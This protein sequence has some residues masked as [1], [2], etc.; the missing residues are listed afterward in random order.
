MRVTPALEPL[1]GIRVLDFTAFPPGGSCTVMLAD[2]GA[3]IIR[4]ESPAQKG[5][6]SLVVGQVALSRGKRSMTLDLRNPASAEV[7]RRLAATVDVIV[8]NAKPGS[9]EERGF[10]YAHAR[11]A[12]PRIIWCA[13]TGFGQSGPY[14]GHAGHDLSYLA[15][16]G[17]LGALTPE[18][19][20]QPSLSLSLQAG[21]FTAVVGIQAAL[22]QRV[23]SGEGAFIDVSLSEA[24]TW[25]LTCGI[26]PLSDHPFVLGATPDRRLYACADGRFVAV[27]CAEPRTWGVLCDILGVP[28]LENNLHKT[29]PA[30]ATTRTL[31]AIFL[32]R[33]AQEWVE[34]LAS[35]G[36]AVTIVN[37]AAQLLEDPHVRARG[38][39]VEAAGTP[40]PANPIR[41]CATDGRQTSTATDGPHKVGADTE[42]V[43][44]AAGF[45]ASEI[46]TLVAEGVI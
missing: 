44:A 19:P 46:A 1:A 17:L 21:A 6:P 38:T 12:N 41:L 31:T 2:L 35:N 33:P 30:E 39:V 24:A 25:F 10:G 13:I 11:A 43:L 3:E 18:R 37:H 29:E 34:R 26:N 8:E 15:H 9:M 5:K 32:T 16:S 27:A 23:Q 14:A 28:Q 36:A 45:P 7:L 22:L 42:D 4:V 20:W 40:V